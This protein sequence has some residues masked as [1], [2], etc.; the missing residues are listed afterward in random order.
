MRHHHLEYEV[1]VMGA[2]PAGLAAAITAAR[3]GRRVVLVENNGYLGGTLAL[4]ISPLS[5][6]DKKGRQTV[7]GFAQEFLDRLQ[8]RGDCLGTEICPKHNSVSSIN[9]EGVTPIVH[10]VMVSKP[11]RKTLPSARHVPMRT[12]L[13]QI[14]P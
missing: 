12:R 5:M 6:L 7:A 11:A 1:A 2:G 4:G 13:R 10:N 14:S 9:A 3:M 8:K